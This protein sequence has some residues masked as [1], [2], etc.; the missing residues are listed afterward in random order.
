M[1]TAITFVFSY[2]C[3]SNIVGA[4]I[5]YCEIRQRGPTTGQVPKG[6][7]CWGLSINAD[8]SGILVL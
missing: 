6:G 3:Y 8:W 2:Y 1:T 5:F 4:T 7:R